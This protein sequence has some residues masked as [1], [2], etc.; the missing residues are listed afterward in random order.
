MNYIELI[1]GVPTAIA[2]LWSPVKWGIN[3][4]RQFDKI[5]AAATPNNKN[6]K[7]H[8]MI[9]KIYSEITPNGGGSIK[10]KINKIDESLHA[11]SDR[12]SLISEK[13]GWMLD[14]DDKILFE[15]DLDGKYTWIN[16]KMKSF[17][18][19]DDHFLLGYGWKNAIHDHE[20]DLV[21]SKWID[22]VKQR[23]DFEDTFQLCNADLECF[24]V[25]CVARRYEGVGYFGYITIID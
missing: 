10:D 15:S 7:F 2:V 6:D 18:K 23:I 17:T 5:L 20:R 3:K 25:K 14:L 24:H 1:I 19:R 8:E 22:C 13:I 12:I 4:V 9:E 21:F 16:K 11:Q